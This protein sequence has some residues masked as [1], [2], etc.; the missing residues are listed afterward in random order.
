MER[1]TWD[2]YRIDIA[3][4]VHM[5]RYGTTKFLIVAISLACTHG[6][7]MVNMNLVDSSVC[8]HAE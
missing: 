5:V 8:F 1:I 6:C 3:S 7:L 4:N 2:K